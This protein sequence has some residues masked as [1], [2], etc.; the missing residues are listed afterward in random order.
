[1]SIDSA[2]V[3]TFTTALLSVSKR[4][5]QA[6]LTKAGPF[7]CLHAVQE[8]LVREGLQNELSAPETEILD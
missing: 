2:D 6:G 5:F 3:Q 4:M 1:V 8:L 7:S